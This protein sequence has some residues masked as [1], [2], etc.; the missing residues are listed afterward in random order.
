MTSVSKDTIRDV[1]AT[2]A[3][4]YEMILNIY[5]ALGVNLKKWRES[6]FERLPEIER[7]RILDVAVGTGTNLPYL[8]EKYPDYQEIVGIDY[9]PQML[10]RAK[11]RIAEN[12]WRDVHTCLIDANGMSE[13]IKGKFDLVIST[14]ALSIIPNS[15]I[16][17]KEI[18]NLI[19]P[20]GYLMLLDCQKFTGLLSIFN[21][22]AIRLS[23]VLGGND[24]TY[25]VPVSDL[26]AKMFNPISRRLLYSGMFYEDLYQGIIT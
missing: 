24:E 26:A 22:M 9:T 14:Y 16:V 21:P 17:L 10:A 6:A 1:Y 13:H 5:R 15:P 12:S 25:S 18:R 23:K 20:R 19:E 3:R 7:P 4:R 2:T 8:I 11:K